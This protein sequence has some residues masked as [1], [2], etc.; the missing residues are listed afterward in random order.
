VSARDRKVSIAVANERD[1]G[2]N[3]LKFEPGYGK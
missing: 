2:R 1:T 3:V